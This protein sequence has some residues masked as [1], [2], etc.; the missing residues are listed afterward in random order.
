MTNQ[1]NKQSS[2]PSTDEAQLTLTLEMAAAQVIETAVTANNNN[3]IP[4][5]CHFLRE[6]QR[7][8]MERVHNSCTLPSPSPS[9]TPSQIL[10]KCALTHHAEE[11]MDHQRHLSTAQV[12]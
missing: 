2:I 6:K 11:K 7:P 10:F 12:L 4:D 5:F 1:V 8:E 9:Q 3:P